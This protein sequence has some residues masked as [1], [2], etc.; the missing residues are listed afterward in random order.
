MEKEREEKIMKIRNQK[1]KKAF[2]SIPLGEVFEFE[3]RLFLKISCSESGNAYDF[4]KGRITTLTTDTLGE[5]ITSELVLCPEY[6]VE[7]KN[8]ECSR[9]TFLVEFILRHTYSCPLSDDSG[10]NF[11]KECVGFGNAGCEECILQHAE[12]LK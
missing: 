6:Q 10:I 7:D 3:N 1:C 4:E 12:L 9:E 8:Q 2:E 5:H 11:E